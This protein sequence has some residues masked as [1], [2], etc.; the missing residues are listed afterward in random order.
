MGLFGPIEV[1]DQQGMRS[2]LLNGQIQGSAYLD[3]GADIL[4]PGVD[5][6]GPVCASRYMLAWLMAAC[7]YPDGSGVMVGLGSGAGPISLLYNGNADL[8]VVEIDPEM[9]EAAEKAFPLLEFY[10]N[11]GRLRIVVADAGDYLSNCVHQFDFGCADG[12][13]GDNQIVDHYMPDLIDRSNTLYINCIDYM[14]GPSLEQQ[15]N[16]LHQLGKPATEVVALGNS[17]NDPQNIVVTTQKDLSKRNAFRPFS[18]LTDRA[19][20]TWQRDWTSL[21]HLNR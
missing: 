7:D 21:L 3:P 14:G 12:Y 20:G 17:P 1:R 6:P 18:D 2:L 11:Q 13:T 15:M 8:T 10:Q 5:G 4:I 16:L 19:A 9:V